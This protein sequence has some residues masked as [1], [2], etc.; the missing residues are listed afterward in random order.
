MKGPSLVKR[1]ALH[2]GKSGG[3]RGL[4]N[5]GFEV[6]F[7]A[8]IIAK[9]SPLILMLCV[10]RR[11]SYLHCRRCDRQTWLWTFSN[12]TY[13]RCR[14]GLGKPE[15][16]NELQRIPSEEYVSPQSHHHQLLS[17]EKKNK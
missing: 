5:L 4:E 7:L 17:A 12:E 14:P 6:P 10:F 1:S 8:I 3:K 2:Q 9:K 13:V 15:S 11:K 16:F